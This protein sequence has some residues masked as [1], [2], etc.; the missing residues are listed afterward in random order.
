MSKTNGIQI[1]WK[2]KNINKITSGASKLYHSSLVRNFN[3]ILVFGKTSFKI[4][5]FQKLISKFFKCY[6]P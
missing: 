2:M 1:K 4:Y 6:I 5:I 3:K